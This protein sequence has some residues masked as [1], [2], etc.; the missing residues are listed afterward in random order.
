MSEFDA[1]AALAAAASGD[2][3]GW[4]SI[5]TAYSGLVWAVARAYRLSTA[6]SADV[7]QGTWLRLV[8]HMASIKDASKLGGWLAT[9]AKREA[10]MLLRRAGRDVPVDPA[11]SLGDKPDQVI[12]LDEQM[13]SA[14]EHRLLWQAFTKLSEN[15]QRLLRVVFADPPPRYAEV[16]A[17]LGIPVGSIGPTRA[18][19]LSNLQSLLAPSR[20]GDT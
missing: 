15:C 20:G 5:V 4:E 1:A 13:I 2:Q 6:D 19:C 3:R 18:R 12:S 11:A 16:S 17:A 7:F 8:E 9:T 14:E 10:L